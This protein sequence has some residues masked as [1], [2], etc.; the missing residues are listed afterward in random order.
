L[1][2][3]GFD[4]ARLADKVAIVTGGSLGKLDVVV[5]N[6]G[7]AGANKPTDEVTAEGRKAQSA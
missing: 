5:N 6:P 4:T 2:E 1:L 7:I 3:E